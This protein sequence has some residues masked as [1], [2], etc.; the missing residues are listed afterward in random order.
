[1]SIDGMERGQNT[2]GRRERSAEDHM[3]NVGG[4]FFGRLLLS[5][6][7]PLLPRISDQRFTWIPKKRPHHYPSFNVCLSFIEPWNFSNMQ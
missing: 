5:M 2:I 4:T 7:F 3:A 6:D 1:M